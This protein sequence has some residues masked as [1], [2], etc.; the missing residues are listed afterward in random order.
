[1]LT[2]H[3]GS[4]ARVGVFIPSSPSRMGHALSVPGAASPVMG[5]IKPFFGLGLNRRDGD[6]IDDI[7]HPTAPA[8]IVY[9]LFEPPQDRADGNG[10]GG[11]LDGFISVV[12]R[13]QVREDENR[14][15]AGHFAIGRLCSG[16]LGIDGG[17]IIGWDLPSSFPGSAF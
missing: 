6:G 12:T 3:N 2:R 9:R 16:D 1:M 13:T 10:A 8:K 7:G 14:G 5:Y 15:L 4:P 11:A 17:V